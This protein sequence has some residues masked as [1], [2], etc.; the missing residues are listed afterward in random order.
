MKS[1]KKNSRRSA[2]SPPPVLTRNEQ[3]AHHLPMF[4]PGLEISVPLHLL[5]EYLKLY[6]L[7]VLGPKQIGWL[8]D[9]GI[10]KRD[11]VLYVR[12]VPLAKEKEND[13]EGVEHVS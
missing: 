8:R 6:G 9:H 7:E 10:R 13:Q 11:G 3:K 1:Y 12:R 2:V 4:G 5:P